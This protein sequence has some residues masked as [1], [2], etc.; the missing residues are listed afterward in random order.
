MSAQ[1]N[2][3][4]VETTAL[5]KMYGDKAAV[6][7]LDLKI[8]EGEIYGFIGRNGAGKSTT[9]K[10]LCGIASPTEGEIL[11]F[12]KPVSDPLVRRRLGVLI[13]SAGLFRNMTA[14][15]NVMMKA[16]CM[17]LADEKS[18]DEVLAKTGLADTGKIGRAHV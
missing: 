11:L 1:R 3:F 15:Q 6:K 17:G 7:Q 14:R 9:L 4:A 8:R 5:T 18:V 16:K 2:I 13:E 10:M 12:G